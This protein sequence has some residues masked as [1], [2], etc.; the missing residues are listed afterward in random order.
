MRLGIARA[1]V[2]FDPEHRKQLAQGLI[3]VDFTIAVLQ[4]LIS[5]NFTLLLPAGMLTR[6]ARRVER[7]KPG[8]KKARKQ[9]QWVKR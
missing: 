5:L 3:L 4:N 6:D 8:Q 2:G 9:F 1:L 7:K